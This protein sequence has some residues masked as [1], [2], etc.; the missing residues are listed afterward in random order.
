M[1]ELAGRVA[2]VTGAGSGIGRAL[3]HRFATEGMRVAVADVDPAALDA[4]AESVR[5]A[6][7]GAEVLTQ[8]TDVRHADAVQVLADRTFAECGQ[9]DL[10]CN[11]AACSWAGSCGSARRRTSPTAST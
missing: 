3:A 6:T 11:N 5:A 4:T 8:P 9:V 1:Q 7:P 10:L 2:V